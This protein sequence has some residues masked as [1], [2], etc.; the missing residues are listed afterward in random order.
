MVLFKI[1]VSQ[2]REKIQYLITGVWNTIFGYGVFALLH[3]LFS[4]KV[5]DFIVLTLSY[6][7]SITNAYIWY[8]LTVFKTKENI[9]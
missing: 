5:S 3:Y 9:L 8:T 2:H 7:L 6:I 1:I 4:G